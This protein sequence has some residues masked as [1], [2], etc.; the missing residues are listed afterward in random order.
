MAKSGQ[1]D[2][3]P[4]WKEWAQ[5]ERTSLQAQAVSIDDDNAHRVLNAAKGAPVLMVSC[6]G[7][8]NET[9]KRNEY[10]LPLSF[11]RCFLG[12]VRLHKRSSS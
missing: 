2:Y 12:R 8:C 3:K 5:V 11:M 10:V 1:L 9:N 4:D 6:L 7:G